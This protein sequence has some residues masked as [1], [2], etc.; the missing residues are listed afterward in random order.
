M[1]DP[2]NT[3]INES[4]DLALKAFT[5]ETENSKLWGFGL[6]EIAILSSEFCRKSVCVFEKSKVV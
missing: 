3:N 4:R 5:T 2:K 1:L 6:Y